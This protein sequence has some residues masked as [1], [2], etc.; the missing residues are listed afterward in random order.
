MVAGCTGSD[1]TPAPTPGITSSSSG[2]TGGTASTGPGETIEPDGSAA[3]SLVPTQ[4]A[5]VPPLEGAGLRYRLVDEVGRPLFCD[6]DFYPVARD[7][8]AVLARQ[9]LATIRADGPTYAAI[10]TRLGIDPGIDPTPAQALAIYRD[11]K[12][13]RALVLTDAAGRFGFD[14]IAADPPGS[15]SGFH[16]VGTIDAAGTIA[17]DR[18]DPAGQPPCPICLARVTLIATPNGDV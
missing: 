16:V 1:K 10:A 11:W 7:D 13:L 5:S 14:Y 8:E 18:R 4:A 9:K 6:P 17:V 3:G 12:M 2:A 15:E